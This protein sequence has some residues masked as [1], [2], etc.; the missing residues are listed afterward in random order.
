MDRDFK[1]PELAVSIIYASAVSYF[2]IILVEKISDDLLWLTY[3]FITIFISIIL[4][5]F[6]IDMKLK[7]DWNLL[8]RISLIGTASLT[9]FS[10]SRLINLFFDEKISLSPDNLYVYTIVF[11]LNSIPLFGKYVL[12]Y[13]KGKSTSLTIGIGIAIAII[14]LVILA[15]IY[16]VDLRNKGVI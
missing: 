9:V 14:S 15:T 1:I 13:K 6:I 16:I 8:L 3:S 2:L 10:F 11:A 12:D 7:I 5:I 4:I